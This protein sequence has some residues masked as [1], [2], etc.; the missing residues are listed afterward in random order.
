LFIWVLAKYHYIGLIKP[1]PKMVLL[2]SVSLQI[3]RYPKPSY[4]RMIV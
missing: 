3:R 2:F 4:Q 1:A